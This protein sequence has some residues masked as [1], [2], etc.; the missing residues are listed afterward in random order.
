M[1]ISS[2]V[3][4]S[5]AQ[6]EPGKIFECSDL[7]VYNKSPDAV[8]KS[9]SRLVATNRLGR[10]SKGKYYVPKKGLLGDMKPSDSELL[11][12][13]LYRKGQRVGY[14]TG[15]AL[16]NKLG[17]STQQPKTIEV[18][19]AGSRQEKNFGTIKIRLVTSLA[20]V[21][22][23]NVPLLELLDVLR[24]VKY[25]SDAPPS[26]VIRLLTV[27]I[28][29]LEEAVVKDLQDLALN[30]YSPSTK[31]LLGFI[32]SCI[33]FRPNPELKKSLSP[34]TKYNIGIDEAEWPSAKEW[35]IR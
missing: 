27:I 33:G 7:D 18:A 25:I 12:S 15:A 29:R 23:K 34:T 4:N 2:C 26:E 30:Y 19:T 35:S 1:T 31:A 22:D 13:C 8:L 21:S 16:F 14:I 11:K 5:I 6:I 17:L 3:E 9:L 28:S 32:I 10:V 24:N 20:P